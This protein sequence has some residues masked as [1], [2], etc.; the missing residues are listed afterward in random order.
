M[1]RGMAT[2]P[3]GRPAAEGVPGP[4]FDAPDETSVALVPR[5]AAVVL[6]VAAASIGWF[7][8]R[9]VLTSDASHTIGGIASMVLPAL[10]ACW[11]ALGVSRRDDLARRELTGWVF[12][13]LAAGAA[14]VF[15]LVVLLPDGAAQGGAVPL[16]G[17]IAHIVLLLCGTIG[18]LHWVRR[19]SPAATVGTLLDLSCVAVLAYVVSWKTILSS[20]LMGTADTEGMIDSITILATPALGTL[21]LVAVVTV[22]SQVGRE[23]IRGSELLATFGLGGMVASDL[24]MSLKGVGNGGLDDAWHDTIL[25]VG[26]VPFVAIGWLL[27]IAAVGFGGALRRH[28]PQVGTQVPLMERSTTWELLVSLI[29]FALLGGVLATTASTGVG[30]GLASRGLLTVLG[31]LLLLRCTLVAVSAIRSSRTSNTD[32]LTHAL[33][34]RQFQERIPIDVERAL[35]SG[36]TYALIAL[37]IDDFGVLNDSYSHAEGDRFLQ[38]VAWSIR[39]VLAPGQLLFRNGGDEFAIALPGLDKAAATELAR[40]VAQATGEI[41]PRTTVSPTLSMG[42]AAVPEDAATAHDLVHVANGTLYWGKLHGKASITAYDPEVVKV[43][44]ADERL[45]VMER[46]ARLRAVLALARALDAR[47]AYT[48]RHSENVSRY[49]V[50][51]ATELGWTTDRLELLRVAGLLHDVG[52]IGVRDSTLRKSAKLSPAEWIE[53][54]GHPVLGARMI[55]GVSPEEIVPWVVSHHERMDGAGYP[56]GLVGEAIPDG[57][58]V[59]AVADTF[60]AMTSS[61]SYR[62]A[63]SPLRA[64]NELVNGAGVQFDP[65]VVRAFISALKR[66]TIDLGEVELAARTAPAQEQHEAAPGEDGELVAV[67]DPEFRRPEDVVDPDAND[68][69]DFLLPSAA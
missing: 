55:A 48:A 26:S 47:D 5:A 25:G 33:S 45:E 27:G 52:K 30:D 10:L 49:S 58:R 15:S 44:S 68:E 23:D 40:R 6:L 53:M 2:S 7:S 32:H 67:V 66:R 69:E 28:A 63:M 4:A 43:L 12:V 39:R 50:A 21:L 38:E 22:L 64:I 1:S 41:R 13:G 9:S 42:I 36:D 54:Q 17:A 35:A 62:P 18:V 29:P 24:G 37:D 60:D 34:H 56:H 11:L 8:L 57:A 61:R 65:D 16:V 20:A 19:L 59:L 14:S 31:A 51:I 3:T 46:N